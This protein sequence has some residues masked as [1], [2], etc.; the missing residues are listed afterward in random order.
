M[1]GR[2]RVPTTFNNLSL[3]I[4]LIL[5]CSSIDIS[6]KT[7][8]STGSVFYCEYSCTLRNIFTTK[9][10]CVRTRTRYLGAKLSYY[11]NSDSCLQLAR[12]AIS[13]DV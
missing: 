12:I 10:A 7:S 8:I 13:G 4:T 3:L 1:A 2:G 11:P 9:A 6:K 5:V